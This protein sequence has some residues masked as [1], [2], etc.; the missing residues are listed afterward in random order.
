MATLKLLGAP[1]VSNVIACTHCGCVVDQDGDGNVRYAVSEN[2][3]LAVVC[4]VCYAM[5]EAIGG[6]PYYIRLHDSWVDDQKNKKR[7]MPGGEYFNG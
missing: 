3:R 4:D 1:T 6:N 7:L 2:N 5:V